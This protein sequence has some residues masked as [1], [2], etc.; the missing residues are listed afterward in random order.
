M[1]TNLT[2]G[3]V[4]ENATGMKDGMYYIAV[5]N[6]TIAAGAKASFSAV[7]VNPNKVVF[8]HGNKVFNGAY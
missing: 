4:V 8:S 3:V 2:P 7:Y 5:N 6:A 1:F